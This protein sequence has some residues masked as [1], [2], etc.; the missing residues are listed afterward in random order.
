MT[1]ETERVDDAVLA[2][3]ALFAFEETRS[4]KSYDWGVMERLHEK[5]LI[6]DPVNKNKSVHLSPEGLA[7]GRELASRLFGA[8]WARRS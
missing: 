8:S 2:L 3:L 5:N 7:K 1:F 6:L 4:W